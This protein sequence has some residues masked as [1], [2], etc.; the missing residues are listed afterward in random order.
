MASDIEDTEK[1][2]IYS[3]EE[4]SEYQTKSEDV[5]ESENNTFD[6]WLLTF[7][8]W[9]LTLHFW[10]LTF[11]FWLLA[12]DFWLLNSDFWLLTLFEI[13]HFDGEI[14]FTWN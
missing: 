7:D 6:S 11:E 4:D 5:S 13:Y 3:S 9:L 10:L 2:Y 12:F 14:L 1:N 8:F